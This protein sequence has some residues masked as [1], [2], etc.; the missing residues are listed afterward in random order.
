MGMDELNIKNER[1][2]LALLKETKAE[3]KKLR[4]ARDKN[5]PQYSDNRFCELMDLGH[6]LET[7]PIRFESLIKKYKKNPDA[8]RTKDEQ[9]GIL[10]ALDYS[11]DMNSKMKER[12]KSAFKEKGLRFIYETERVKNGHPEA[13]QK[14]AEVMGFISEGKG[15]RKLASP[16]MAHDISNYY[17][18]CLNA[19]LKSKEAVLNIFNNKNYQKL[20][21]WKHTRSVA[22][23]L[24]K[25]GHIEV[26]DD[27]YISARVDS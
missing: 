21:N 8:K 18:S 6:A 10:L 7:H 13:C 15:K 23:I 11:I 20:F 12:L 14:V 3:I 27:T 17:Q 24:R 5:D 1:E 2:R 26:W 4:E 22:Y 16:V 25:A 19:G 9:D